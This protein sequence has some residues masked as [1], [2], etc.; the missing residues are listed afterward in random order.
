MDDEQSNFFQCKELFEKLGLKK[1]QIE[2]IDLDSDGL[3]SCA[4][5]YGNRLKSKISN[6]DDGFPVFDLILLGMGPDG[7]TCSLFP[8]HKLLTSSEIVDFIEDSPKPPKERITLTLPTLIASKNVVF[9]AFGED[10]DPVLKEILG[11]KNNN[12]NAQTKYPA[13]M[14]QAQN[15]TW[16]VSEFSSSGIKSL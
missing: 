16:L 10:K 9:V 13:Q 7:H 6:N 5:E 15:T 2:A 11:E 12:A 4:E 8:G 14:V 3:K 1:D